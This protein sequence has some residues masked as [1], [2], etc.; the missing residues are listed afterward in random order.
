MRLAESRWATAVV[1][2]LALAVWWLQAVVIP[3]GPGRDLGTYLGGYVQLFQAH[4]IDLG[5]VLGRT[6]IAMLVVGGLLDFAGGVFAEPVMSIL[7]A[8]SIVAWFLAA[9][10]FGARAAVLT[11]VV[12]LLY[13]GYGILFHELSSDAVFAAAFAGWSLLVVRVLRAPS[14]AGFAL[15]GAGVGVLALVRPGNQVL[16]AA[17][18]LPLLLGDTVRRRLVGAAAFLAPA[19]ILIAGWAVHNGVRYDNYIVARGGNATVPFFRAF[20]TDKIVRPSNGPESEELAR[21]VQRELLP[22]EPYRSYGITL[23]DFFTKA[24][25]RMQVDLLALSD[26]LKGWHSNY[27]WLRDVGVEAVEEHPARYARGVLGS[28]SGMLRLALYR[29]PTSSAPASSAGGG[30]AET[31]VGDRVLP[32]P[33]EGEPIPAAHEGGVTTPDY[34]IRTVWTS[35]TEHHLVF[36]HPGDEARYDAL[37]R[38]MDELSANLPDRTGSAS[39]AHR[40]NQASHRFPPPI[41]WL[42]VGLVALAVRRLMGGKALWVPTLS[43][44]GVIVVSALGLPAEPHYSVPVAPAFV[45]FAGGAVF[46]ARRQLAPVAGWRAALPGILRRAGPALGIAA[47]LLAAVVAVRRFASVIRAGFENDRAPHDLA[48]FLHAAGRVL[49]GASPFA[50]RADET[51]AYPPFLAYLVSPLHP[52]GAGAATLIWTAVGLACLG[53]ALWLLGVTDWR[54]YALAAAFEFTRS[55]IALGT[56]APL[57][58]LAL[59]VAWKWRARLLE[60]AVAVGAGIALKLFLW[61]FVLWSYLTR[62]ARAALAAVA[63]AAG[64][65]LI[66]W[67]G[68]GFAGLTGY[69]GLL[70]HLS[71]D[72]ATSSYSVVA[73]TVRAHLPESVGVVVSVVV[74]VALLAAAVWVWRQEERPVRS[75]EV[76]AMTLVLA[77][78]LAASPIVWVHYFLLL[79]VPLALTSPRLSWLWFVPVAYYPLGES[80]WPA[81]DARKLALGLA[82]TLVILGTT[83]VRALRP[84][85]RE[86]ERVEPFRPAGVKD[87][88]F[89]FDIPGGGARYRCDHRAEQLRLAGTTSDVVQTARIDL[90]AVVDHYERFVLNRVEWTDEVAEFLDRVR[91]AG[92]DV[93]FDTD[94]LIFEPGLDRCFAF[95]DSWPEDS[96]RAEIAL[97]DRYRRTLEACGR[98]TV[99]T[100]PLAEAALKRVP[101]VEVVFNCVGE[102]M[103]RLADE[104]VASS[105]PR[106]DDVTIA[107]LSGTR[108]HDKDF[109]EAADAVLWALETYPQARFLAVGKLTLDGRFDAFGRRVARV[110]LQPWQELP[111]ILAGVDVNLAPLERDNPVT[112]C[113]SCV[114]YLEAGLVGVPTLASRRPDFVRV[115]EE[116]ENGLLADTPDEWRSALGE[117]IVGDELRHELGARA[118]EDIRQNHTTRLHAQRISDDRIQSSSVI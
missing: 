76:A 65:V 22:K 102:E 92:K 79:L 27:R 25:P 93:V 14:T 74:A 78:A 60:P 3:L 10:A 69:P 56:T 108:T 82:A 7:Y 101:E 117:L 59:A 88:L 107:Y 8:G 45:L 85:D 29:S 21:A 46:A 31:V 90:P 89:V 63:F 55:A 84:S 2:A 4:P 68:I 51:Y 35:P 110:P 50:Y 48:V 97:L 73:L 26:R 36:L 47:G 100:E 58:L 23:D 19:V 86:A 53:A 104:A 39:L 66:P 43:G 81:G 38:R 98:A 37:H 12:L 75:R 111:R 67:A 13:P 20:V 44:L 77:A 57:L 116:G 109:L 49:D 105:D 33:S 114:K 32:T 18:L 112:A 11:V 64:F 1:F 28:V 24:S 9:R 106:R 54:C 96:R 91:A 70:R 99:S 115:I 95:M 5:F 83:L 87:T 113:K 52:L 30:S 15:V 40:L 62:G 6:P 16:L 34:S 103:V 41:V 71:R 17:V 61:P 80:A 72:E 42:V 118:A 94:D